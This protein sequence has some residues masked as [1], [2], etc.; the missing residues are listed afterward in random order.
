MGNNKLLWCYSFTQNV[1]CCYVLRWP[2]RNFFPQWLKAGLTY[3]K[4]IL[5]VQD[6]VLFAASDPH[7]TACLWTLL[8][9][10]CDFK[11]VA[12][13]GRRKIR[14]MSIMSCLYYTLDCKHIYRTIRWR[15]FYMPNIKRSFVT[16][17]A[18]RSLYINRNETLA[19]IFF[20]SFFVI[21]DICLY[22]FCVF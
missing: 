18:D 6:A 8:A 7:L 5:Y 16:T 19:D 20:C 14:A 2:D 13:E 22:D 4:Q 3:P 17:G 9:C 1:S 11:L 12:I 21:L 15:C 10:W